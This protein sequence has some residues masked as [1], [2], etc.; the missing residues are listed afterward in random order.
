MAT[1]VNRALAIAA[2]LGVLGSSAYAA[3]FSMDFTN[4]VSG[5]TPGGTSP[6]ASAVFMDSAPD[7]VRLVL[8][9]NSGSA[10]GQF[11]TQVNLNVAPGITSVAAY[12]MD[13][14]T[15][16]FQ[17]YSFSQVTNAGST[18]DFTLNFGT[19]AANGGVAR[20]N[21]GESVEFLLE[22][23]GLNANSFNAY[24]SGGTPQLG[25]VHIQGLANGQ[26]AKLGAEA[27]PEPATMAALAGLGLAVARRRK[28]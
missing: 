10:A 9:H 28:K 19:S 3:S 12:A 8:T 11:L 15:T 5:P 17:N 18:Y 21:P 26:S 16:A 2:T 13:G 6:Y 23:A 24:S 7:V 20:L 14:K 22:G 25:L 27:V 1:Y 4:V